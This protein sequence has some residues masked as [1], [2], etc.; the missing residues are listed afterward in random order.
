L[1]LLTAFFSVVVS[2][3][4]PTT[5]SNDVGRYFRADTIYS[6]MI[7]TNLPTKLQN[8][9]DIRAINYEL[10]RNF[11]NVIEKENEKA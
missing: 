6:S 10:F 7:K 5:V 2:A 4:C 11:A 3:C 8:I 9:Y 1:P